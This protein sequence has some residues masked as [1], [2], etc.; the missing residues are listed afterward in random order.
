MMYRYL[1]LRWNRD[2]DRAARVAAAIA[3]S[4]PEV[5]PHEWSRPWSAP[6]IA[7]F[8]S[9]EAKGRMQT[10]RLHNDSGVVLGRLFRNGSDGEYHSQIDDFGEVDTRACLDSKGQH[11]IDKFW[12]RYVTFLHEPDSGTLFVMRDPSG[13]FPCFFTEYEDVE[14]YFSDMQDAANFE[15][16]PFTVNWEYI[17]TNIMLPQYQ[18]THTGLNEVGEIL[19]AECVEIAPEGRTSRF[20]W[21]PYEIAE[22]DPI[23]D[24]EEAAKLLRKTVRN[25]IQALSGCYDRIIHNLGGLDSSIALAC[26]ADAPDRP[27]ITCVTHYTKSLRGEERFYSRQAANKAGVPLVECELDYRNANLSRVFESN[28][29]ANPLGF[30]DCIG[31]N[32]HVLAL[33][34]E[35]DA[36]ALFYGVGGDQVFYQPPFNLAALDYVHYHGFGRDT[37]KVAMEA[38]RYGR[39][40]LATTLRSMVRERFWPTPCYDYVHDVLFANY[41]LPLVNPDFVGTVGHEC[42]LHPLLQPDDR[43]AKG[44]YLHILMSAF[45]SKEYYNHWDADY[46]AE[47]VH[48]YLTQPIIEVCLRIPAWVMTYAGIERGL[49]RK[50]FRHDLPRDVVKR[51]S[52]TGPDAYYKDIF[53]HNIDLVRDCLGDGIMARQR[54]FS[55]ER[56][57]QT[58]SGE[59]VF[60][61]AV[62]HRIL[63]Y[64]AIEA[65]IRSWAERPTAQPRRLTDT[66]PSAAG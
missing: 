13:A 30:F 62:P 25:T 39:K 58:L 19:P 22:T 20:V 29:L 6:G 2:N 28:K 55:Q 26:M 38:S 63:G 33:A 40:T 9:G 12:G 4:L 46:L 35:K 7:V 31:L 23:E 15:F 57:L 59:D 18:K 44:K 49:A 43:M 50:T 1:V 51:V 47:R 8:H 24:P 56:L 17:K 41:K 36:Q 5:S 61:T 3:S 64:L 52:K 37:L 21:N 65:W 48:V 60:L 32:G 27:E 45:A 34:R 10:Y 14:I 42:F 16:L 11:L 66:M 53:E 54:I